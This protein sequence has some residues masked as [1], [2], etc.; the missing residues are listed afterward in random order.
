M[1]RSWRSGVLTPASLYRMGPGRNEN[2]G[3]GPIVERLIEELTNGNVT[4]VKVVLASVALALAPYQLLLAA[5]AYGKLRARLLEPG[6]A[7]WT[8]RASGDVILVLALLVAV[9]CVSIYGFDDDAGAHS[10]FGLFGA[11]DGAWLT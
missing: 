6:L 4:E 8:H 11:L 9:A 1:W 3:N 5:V 7:S 2:S 10:I